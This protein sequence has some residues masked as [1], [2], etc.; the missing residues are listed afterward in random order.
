MSDKDQFASLYDVS[1][2]TIDR[3]QVYED[4]LKKWTIRI[5]LVAKSTLG[6]VWSRHF[7][8]SAQVFEAIPKDARIL[9]DF[10]S[11]G[12]FPGLVIAAMASEK[13]P[14]L[15]ISL[16]E[17][18]ARKASFLMTAAREMGLRATIHVDRVESVANQKADVVTARALAPLNSLFLMAEQHLK[19]G[20]TALFLK[21]EKHQEELDTA[22]A[23]WD[24]KVEKQPSAT[25]DASALLVIT[26]LR[27]AK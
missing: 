10:G 15:H 3:L 17:S 12:G 9:C 5:N 7:S 4:L 1:R 19:E 16:I 20:G 6:D 24:F 11:G 25:N 23:M 14:E 8:D 22:S 2:E 21:G 13:L 27:R 26:N 18:D